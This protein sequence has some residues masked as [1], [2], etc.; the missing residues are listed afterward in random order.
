MGPWRGLRVV[1][2][3][4]NKTKR[5]RAAEVAL[6]VALTE[7]YP[8]LVATKDVRTLRA[9]IQLVRLDTTAADGQPTGDQ[10]ADEPLAL[11]DAAPADVQPADA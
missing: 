7:F 10:V 1:A 2:I 5:Q 8:R 6:A 3:G 11:T 9:R 4:S